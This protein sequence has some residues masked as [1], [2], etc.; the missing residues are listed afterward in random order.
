MTRLGP[1]RSY[2]I[3][4]RPI[5]SQLGGNSSHEGQARNGD[6]FVVY[7][8]Y[9]KYYDNLLMVRGCILLSIREI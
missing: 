2:S 3:P 5:H 7:C 1:L 6:E 8:L 9:S 4:Y